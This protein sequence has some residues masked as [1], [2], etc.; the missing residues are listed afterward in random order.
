MLKAMRKAKKAVKALAKFKRREYQKQI[1]DFILRHPRCNIWATMGAG[2][3]GSVL[4]V[5]NYLF[6]CGE[7]DEDEDKVVI[8]APVRVASGTWPT[9]GLKFSFPAVRAVDG[10]GTA[11]QRLDALEELENGANVLCINYENI[12]WLIEYYGGPKK[13]PF[14]VIV[15]DESTRLKSFRT[16]Q[17]ARRAKALGTV[18]HLPIVE[19]FINLTGTP[20]PL[21]LKDLWGQCWFIDGGKSL[22]TSYTAFTERWFINRPT[23]GAESRFAMTSTLLEGSEQEI[24]DAVEPYSL[25]IDAAEFFGVDKPNFI[26]IG[27]D[28]PPKARRIYKEMEDNFIVELKSILDE[29]GTLE[30]ANAAAKSAKCLQIA[31]GACYIT[32]EDGEATKAWDEVHKAKLEALESIIEE[33]SGAPLLVAYNFK[34]DLERLKKRF[35]QGVALRKGKKGNKDLEDWNKGKIPILFAHPASAGHGLNLQ[36]GGCHLAFFG[37]GWSLECYQQIIERIGPTRQFQAGHPRPVIVY[38][39][40]AKDTL[41]YAVLERMQGKA[42]TQQALMNYMKKVA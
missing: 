15:A 35:P 24:Y 19:F 17:G 18:A 9:E 10:T 34:H 28:L 29:G 33:L 41:D 25:T 14:K 8:L 37:M 1:T 13:W 21:G 12:E 23:P 39:I 16:R 42:S 36:D 40:L 7:L 26:N 11:K 30:A 3:T 38:H 31:A 6:Q 20:S 27:V 5:L 4:W 22:G 2:K 32:D